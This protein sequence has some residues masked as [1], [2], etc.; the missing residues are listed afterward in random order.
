MP[1]RWQVAH[2]GGNANNG[3]Q[4]GA[5][6]VNTNNDSSNDNDNIGR[7]LSL[8]EP[9]EHAVAAHGPCLLAKHKTAPRCW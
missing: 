7:Q 5:F 4:A 6:N 9:E 1:L 8:F 2:F 3:A